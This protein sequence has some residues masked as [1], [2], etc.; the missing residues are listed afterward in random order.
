MKRVLK[1]ARAGSIALL[2]FTA[3]LAVGQTT[4][5]QI[6]GTVVDPAGAVV[7]G[8]SVEAIAVDT[9]VTRTVQTNS[10]GTYLLTLLPPGS[11]Q[12]IISKTG[13]Q[14]LTENDIKLD[15]NQTISINPT[16]SVGTASISVEVE[17]SSQLIDSSTSELGTVIGE[18][19]VHDLPL[20]GRN[21]TQLL[22]LVPG[23]TPISTSQGHYQG[24]DDGSTVAIRAALLRTPR[25]TASRTGNRSTCSTAS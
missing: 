23:A 10:S 8:V 2:L 3:S 24:T 1:L 20:N 15:V 5:G 13:F 9:K 21:F 7:P 16:L 19:P 22:T 25:S 6:S 12:V 18:R 11:Y 14:P 4:T 17:A